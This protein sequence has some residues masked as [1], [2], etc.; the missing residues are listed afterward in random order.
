MKAILFDSNIYDALEHDMEAKSAI[1][2]LSSNGTIRVIATPRVQDELSASPFGGI[3]N[4]FPVAIETESVAV[5]GF[6]RLGMAR[7]GEGEVYREHRGDSNQASDAVIA[8][9]ANDLADFFVSEDKRARTRLNAISDS[10]IAMSYCE[11][12]TWLQSRLDSRNLYHA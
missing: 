3:P 4:W 12:R 5:L 7:L 2:T 6:W 11:F 1:N 8:D 9:S 10:C